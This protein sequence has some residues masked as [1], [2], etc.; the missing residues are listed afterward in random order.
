MTD[1]I[2]PRDQKAVDTPETIAEEL[3]RR[4][5]VVTSWNQLG[6]VWMEET[7]IETSQYRIGLPSEDTSPTVFKVYFPPN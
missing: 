5:H 6:Q 3:N 2:D 1:S 4:G 7:G